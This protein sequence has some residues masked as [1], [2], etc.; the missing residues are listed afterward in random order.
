MVRPFSVMVAVTMLALACTAGAVPTPPRATD[1]LIVNVDGRA[2]VSLDGRWQVLIDPIGNGDASPT[3]LGAVAS[4]VFQDRRPASGGELIEYQFTDRVAL[5]VPGDW[6]TQDPR[7]FFYQG[8]IWYRTTFARPKNGARHFLYFGAVNYRADVYVNGR[9]VASSE[10]GFTPFNVEITD[11]LRDGDNLLVLKV[12]NTLGAETVPPRKT[13]W[14]NYGGITRS[15]R[16]VSTPSTFV[17][18]YVVRLVDRRRREIRVTVTLDGPGTTEPVRVRIPEL[19]R[20][21]LIPIGVDGR[22]E[23]RFV[24]PVEFWSPERP[25][26]YDVELSLGSV[27]VRDRIG[28]RTIERAGHELLLNGRPVF[29]RGVSMHEESLDH[30]GRSF[31]EQDAR[32][33]LLLA[34]ELGCNFVRLA[35]YP[36]DEATVRMADELGLLVWAEVP[37]YWSVA[38]SNASAA[39]TAVAQLDANVRRDRNRAAVIIWSVA[40]ETPLGEPRLRFLQTLVATVRALDDS[41][42]VSAA[43]LGDKHALLEH[44]SHVLMANVAIDPEVTPGTREVAR[45]W[46]GDQLGSGTDDAALRALAADTAWRIDDPIGDLLDVV[47]YN[48]YLGW[49]PPGDLA[50]LLPVDEA[51]LRETE[52]RLMPKMR[53]VPRQD[54]PLIISEFGADAKAGFVGDERTV[55]SEAF[56]ARIYRAQLA[57]VANSPTVRG[58]SPWILKDFRSA[59]R[60][61]PVYQ[62]YWN[63]KGLVSESG[64]RKRAFEVLQAFYRQRAAQ[65]NG[66]DTR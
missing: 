33:S 8:P 35:H 34:K 56:Q 19:G 4:G 21:V 53:I 45:R 61:H 51:T 31:G 12:D 43:L 1:P 13:D 57:L 10:G 2:A 44:Y 16:L 15:V 27:T 39:R 17:R 28:F 54:L 40:N 14:L 49:Y 47:A 64:Q 52:I 66:P 11:R 65:A 62:E 3:D 48:E 37:V 55:F 60:S 63:R 58:V 24:A 9:Y 7:L 30:P 32:R 5:N 25:R 46:L 38:W 6:N 26:L 36:H 20:E 22:G 59:L 23:A 29:L 50:R 42:L 41:R 18:D